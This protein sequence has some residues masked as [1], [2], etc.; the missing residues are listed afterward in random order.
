[1]ASRMFG[2]S[3][4]E[5]PGGQ[6]TDYAMKQHFHEGAVFNTMAYS[7]T[8]LVI[9]PVHI[10]PG[11]SVAKRRLLSKIGKK[12]DLEKE[13]EKRSVFIRKD[14]RQADNCPLQKRNIQ[15][16]VVVLDD[17][18]FQQSPAKRFSEIKL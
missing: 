14:A 12:L 2:L 18:S 11:Q 9:G 16:A 15:C 1:M 4:P 3:L 10:S 17:N 6:I 13:I 8:V 5:F 7:N